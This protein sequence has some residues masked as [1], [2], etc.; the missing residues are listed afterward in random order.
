MERRPRGQR[1]EDSPTHRGEDQ[2]MIAI[3]GRTSQTFPSGQSC[4]PHLVHEQ[5]SIQTHLT[6]AGPT[7]SHEGEVEILRD[8]HLLGKCIESVNS[9]SEGASGSNM[10]PSESSKTRAKRSYGSVYWSNKDAFPV[11]LFPSLRV[12]Q[13]P[14]DLYH[15]RRILSH[16][17]AMLVA[18]RGHVDNHISVHCD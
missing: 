17:D 13:D 4:P 15:F 10:L 11:E 18:S 12:Q 1:L 16:V 7:L 2:V 9:I 6:R 5:S 14:T 3:R 8:E